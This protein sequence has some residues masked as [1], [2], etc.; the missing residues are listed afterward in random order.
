MYIIF[1]SKLHN[2]WYIL[3]VH[4][5]AAIPLV[6]SDVS[7]LPVHFIVDP[8]LSWNGIDCFDIEDPDSLLKQYL[9]VQMIAVPGAEASCAD[10]DGNMNDEN[11]SHI[12]DDISTPTS[13]A[14]PKADSWNELTNAASD[15]SEDTGCANF[16]LL[17]HDRRRGSTKEKRA[18]GA[19]ECEAGSKSLTLSRTKLPVTMQSVA[20]SFGSLGRSF[21]RLRK[22]ITRIAHRNTLKHI[23]KPVPV[24]TSAE[25]SHLVANYLSNQ[26]Y[27]ICAGLLHRRQPY[28]EDMVRNYL[29][30]AAERFKCE[31]EKQQTALD[32]RLNSSSVHDASAVNIKTSCVNAGCEG[33]GD[34]STAYLCATCFEHQQREEI[35]S[36]MP[37]HVTASSGSVVG[38]ATRVPVVTSSIAQTCSLEP[39]SIH[40]D[41]CSV[42]S[43]SAAVVRLKPSTA[44]DSELDDL[45]RSAER[46]PSILTKTLTLRAE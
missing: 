37:S 11:D 13:V 19:V 34:A 40:A 12:N 31:C 16:I 44:L 25:H 45:Q 15:D 39:E 18:N 41:C 20:R 33:V 43:S 22:N 8:G 10:N 6:D 17:H 32:D 21:R 3:N 4:F 38:I 27:I 29:A 46:L 24:T 23:D 35:G 36:A 7:P 5:S 14:V 28:Q 1:D 26:N 42:L 2:L 30:S 9:D